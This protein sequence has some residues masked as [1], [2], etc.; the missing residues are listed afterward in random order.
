MTGFI[1][2]LWQYCT[3]QTFLHL[4]DS[5]QLHVAARPYTF[6]EED[7]KQKGKQGK[8]ITSGA[9]A[10]IGAAGK[11]GETVAQA[12]RLRS[13]AIINKCVAHMQL[14]LDDPPGCQVGIAEAAQYLH[15]IHEALDCLIVG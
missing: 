12:E 5:K 1:R 3:A 15:P 10:S 2:H 7:V 8:V 9:R 13:D 6:W 4:R 14:I 11:V